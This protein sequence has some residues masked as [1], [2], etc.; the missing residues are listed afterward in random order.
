MAAKTLKR[1]SAWRV[2]FSTDFTTRAGAISSTPL[3]SSGLLLLAIHFSTPTTQ[4][5]QPFVVV[6]PQRN[7]IQ[8]SLGSISCK[9]KKKE[10]NSL[11]KRES[12]EEELG[13]T[14]VWSFKVQ[15]LRQYCSIRESQCLETWEKKQ[16]LAKSNYISVGKIPIS[17]NQGRN[18]K[19]IRIKCIMVTSLQIEL[20]DQS[21]Q[22]EMEL[23]KCDSEGK[24][25][26]NTNNDT[27]RGNWSYCQ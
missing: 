14:S 18:I 25:L 24:S 3:Y 22:Q 4:E 15:L 9:K 23:N 8:L 20:S 26:L 5:G 17:F 1:L 7:Q 27:I 6:L 11:A 2:V 13:V 10:K 12:I 21:T 16:S 19:E